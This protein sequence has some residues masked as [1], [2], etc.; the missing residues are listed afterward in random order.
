[1]ITEPIKHTALSRVAVPLPRPE[2]VLRT[3]IALIAAICSAAGLVDPGQYRAV[4][5]PA[6]LPG[7]LGQDATALAL[8]VVL[9][10]ITARRRSADGFALPALAFLAYGYGIYS[11]ERTVTVWYI[12]YLAA[13]ACA[14]WAL[15]LGVARVLRAA[16]GIAPLTGARRVMIAAL[17]GL[18]SLAFSAAWVTALVPYAR[19]GRQ[20]PELW[21]IYLMDLCFVMPA[22][23]TAAWWTWRRDPRGR[24]LGTIM[25]GLGALMMASLSLAEVCGPLAGLPAEPLAA[26]PTLVLTAVF[27]A[28]WV[29]RR[30]GGT[31]DRS[32]PR[33]VPVGAAR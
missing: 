6:V 5:S 18:T 30:L 24:A 3:A 14:T 22:L 11:I 15:V 21:S 23:A 4:V 27:A 16:A 31:R 13:L 10:V 7:A 19:T 25:T 2:A 8:A 26:M 17:C 20:P 1:M 28:G 32:I 29:M 9:L 33:A 12:A